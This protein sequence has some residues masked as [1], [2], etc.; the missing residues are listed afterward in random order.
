MIDGKIE[1]ILSE[2]II[3][4][5]K[6]KW[7]AKDTENNDFTNSQSSKNTCLKLQNSTNDSSQGWQTGYN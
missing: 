6:M 7:S 3:F 1:Q 4:T 2:Y 5:P